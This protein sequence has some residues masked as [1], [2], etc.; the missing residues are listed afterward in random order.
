VKIHEQKFSCFSDLLFSL[1]R[2]FPPGKNKPTK[3]ANKTTTEKEQI[4][5]QEN[6]QLLLV[7]FLNLSFFLCV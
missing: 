2:S 6:Y 4:K 3:Q 1:Q 7:T 5:C